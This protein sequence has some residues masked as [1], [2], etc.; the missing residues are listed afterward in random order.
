MENGR[1]YRYFNN[2]NTV[3][4][5]NILWLVVLMALGLGSCT[6]ENFTP[7]AFLHIDAIDLVESS[8]FSFMSDSGFYRSDIVAA[9][10]TVHYPDAAEEQNIG[11]F[12]LPFT[13]PLLYDGTIDYVKIAPAIKQSG[14]IARLPY[15]TFYNRIKLSNV[16]VHTGDT[17]NF[18]T[19]H[20]TYESHAM[21]HLFE[22]FEPNEG[23]ISTFDST[24]IWERNAR[25]EACT[26]YG[27][28]RIHVP[29]T[30]TN[31][32]CAMKID[33]YPPVGDAIYLELDIRSELPVEVQMYGR[34][35]SGTN[36]TRKGVMVI[37]PTERWQHLYINLWPTFSTFDHSAGASFRLVLS[38]LNTELTGGEVCID[39]VKIISTPVTN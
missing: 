5:N 19:L 6:D 18:G 38:A 20:T 15:Y 39:N 8:N 37:Y 33:I 3:K 31:V 32:D 13:T 28:G 12:R 10:V 36:E 23:S 27:Y 7:P 21:P 25:G 14:Q 30:T 22:A 4:R 16:T 17:L 29:D 2:R 1:F 24:I 35:M 34:E 26:G 9:Y 11:L